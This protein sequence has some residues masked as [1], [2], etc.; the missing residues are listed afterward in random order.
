MALRQVKAAPSATAELA[1]T[2]AQNTPPGLMGW[3]FE[4]H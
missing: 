4:K 1:L 3:G 2:E